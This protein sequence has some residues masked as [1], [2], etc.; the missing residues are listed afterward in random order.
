MIAVA[1]SVACPLNDAVENPP[2]GIDATLLQTLYADQHLLHAVH[3]EAGDQQRGACATADNRRVGDR[4]DRWRID[5]HQIVAFIR[6][7]QQLLETRMHQ[8]LRRIRGDL[9]A[10][11]GIESAFIEGLNA[12]GILRLTGQHF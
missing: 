12:L 10:H 6:P 1:V 9:P 2:F 3:P 4:Q 7:V 5:N 8:K 11:D